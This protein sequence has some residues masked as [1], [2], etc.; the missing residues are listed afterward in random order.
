MT[1]SAEL[2]IFDHA[3]DSRE[4]PAFDIGRMGRLTDEELANLRGICPACDE[5]PCNIP[6]CDRC[7]D[8]HGAHLTEI[9]EGRERLF[10]GGCVKP[11]H[12]DNCDKPFP[13]WALDKSDLGSFCVGC[14]GTD[15]TE[16]L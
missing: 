3:R 9:A 8:K 12:C 1:T 14:G 16:V 15:Q 6:L 10:C 13:R 2:S 7:G 4:D 11:V 5:R